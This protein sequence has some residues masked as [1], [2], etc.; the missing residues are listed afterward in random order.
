MR[1]EFFF[2]YMLRGGFG[3]QGFDWLTVLCL[4]LVALFMVGPQLLGHP[5]SGRARACFVGTTWILVV[6]LFLHLIQT[7]LI[8]LDM[9]NNMV[10]SR[11]G[12]GGPGQFGLTA[13][14]M[15]FFPVIEGMLFVLAAVLF[16]AGLP[17]MV[18]QKD[19]WQPE[20]PRREEEEA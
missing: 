13:V 17:G 1:D 18:R 16:V 2:F 3:G 10:G 12:G 14:V 8:G 11:G 19:Q 9:F 15:L 5:L 4:F 20:T 7:L 6:K